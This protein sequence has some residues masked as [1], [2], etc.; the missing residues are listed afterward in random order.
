MSYLIKI[1]LRLRG[2]RE[3]ERRL[4]ARNGLKVRFRQSLRDEANLELDG[5]LVGVV[6]DTGDGDPDEELLGL[7]AGEAGDLAVGEPAADGGVVVDQVRGEV[8][9]AGRGAQLHF[10]DPPVPIV[11]VGDG[12]ALHGIRE[13]PPGKAVCRQQIMRRVASD[14]SRRHRHQKHDN[15]KKEHHRRSRRCH[16][17]LCLTFLLVQVFPTPNSGGALDFV[18]R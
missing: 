2:G 1:Y 12:V 13:E 16:F 4:A 3:G 10:E 11:V 15:S 7:N 5:A 6:Q 18:Q 8:H 9:V 17:S 14:R